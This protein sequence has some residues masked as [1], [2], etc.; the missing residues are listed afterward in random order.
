MPKDHAARAITSELKPLLLSHGFIRK[1]PKS[2]I[3]VRGDLV[4][5][6][7]FQMSQYGSKLFYLH[8]FCNL[9]PTPN[10]EKLLSTNLIG[11]RLQRGPEGPVWQADSESAAVDAM[12]NVARVCIE[13]V[14]PWFD[15]MPEVGS[16][17]IEY[18]A[19]SRSTLLSYEVIAGLLLLGHT[20]RPW[21]L[22][23]ELSERP[24]DPDW[25]TER[26][27]LQRAKAKEYAD[28]IHNDKHRELL[29]SWRQAAFENNGLMQKKTP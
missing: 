20:S 29:E 8:Y 14:I 10:S 19:S 9:I 28:L 4:D 22:L 17:L 24:I 12:K 5:V 1:T 13:Q 21:W 18:I 16:W 7:S 2:F 11:N 26:Q 25:N 6:I 15:N 3:R 23:S 27:K